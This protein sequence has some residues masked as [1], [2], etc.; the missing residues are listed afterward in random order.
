L[1]GRVSLADLVDWAE[2]TLI[3]PNIP[4]TEDADTVMDVLAYLGAADTRGFPL[5]WNMLN[6]FIE[7]LGGHVTVEVQA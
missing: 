3:D 7:Q 5:T 4:E 1:N 2:T 6:S